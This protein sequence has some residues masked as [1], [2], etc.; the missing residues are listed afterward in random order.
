M[1][2]LSV[3]GAT[4]PVGVGSGGIWQHVC[5]IQVASLTRINPCLSSAEAVVNW[6]E[7]YEVLDKKYQKLKT[8]AVETNKVRSDAFFYKYFLGVWELVCI[9][10]TLIPI[11]HSFSNECM[12]VVQCS[13]ILS[14]INI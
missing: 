6:K 7:A 1:A 4:A 14:C 10:S 2:S 11:V 13:T 12:C 8:K 3:E 9:S 5:M